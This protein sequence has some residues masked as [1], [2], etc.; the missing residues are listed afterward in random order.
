[1]TTCNLHG[2]PLWAIRRALVCR[3][4][5]QTRYQRFDIDVTGNIFLDGKRSSHIDLIKWEAGKQH[6]YI[7]LME[8]S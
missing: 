1:M 6:C 7:P 8:A 4:N 3:I 5:L 2:V